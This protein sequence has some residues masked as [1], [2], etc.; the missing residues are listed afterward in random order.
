MEM[1]ITR[2]VPASGKTTWAKAWTAEETTLRA[3]VNRDDIRH[4][5]FGRG[6][7]VDE[8]AV[9]VIQDA[10]IR[11]HLKAGRSVVVDNTNLRSSHVR[12]LLKIAAQFNT[13][14][15]IKDFHITRGEACQRDALRENPV[16][17]HVIDMF[18]TRYVSKYGAFP[19]APTLSEYDTSAFAPYVPDKTLP[20]AFGF[21]LDGTL[22]HMDGRGPYD[23]SKYHTDTVDETV[24]ILANTLKN[25]GHKIV[26]L[27]GRSD[28]FRD[29][30]ELWLT[31]NGI[32]FDAVY[33]RVKDDIRRDDIV[34]SEMFDRHVAPNYNFLMQFD[35]RNR[36][37]D[38]LRQKNIKVAQ[39][40]VGNF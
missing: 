28:E 36:V 19:A 8:R 17:D 23:N 4:S 32:P 7:G 31:D 33:M 18:F 13:T 10:S 30:C 25:A 38:A 35:D 3:R 6:F 15:E 22:A 39:V 27:T 26:I 21:D 5:Q 2:G 20:T 29:V 40:A 16:G 37:V 12:A 24:K 1:I 14:V 11:A 9:T 34:K